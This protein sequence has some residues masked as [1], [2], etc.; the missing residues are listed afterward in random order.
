MGTKKFFEEATEQSLAKVRI[1]SKYFE[2]WANVVGRYEDKVAYID[3]FCG[4]GRYEDGKKSTPLEVLEKAIAD[5]K[6]RDK[7]VS[8]FNDRKQSHVETLESE[9]RALSGVETL[10]YEPKLTC[11]EVDEAVVRVFEEMKLIP[12]LLFVDPWGY[13]GITL[14][15]LKA[16]LKD[17]GCD[18]VLFFNYSRVNRNLGTPL[19]D[20]HMERLFGARR[21]CSLRRKIE[22]EAKV[23]REECIVEEFKSAV[24]ELGGKYVLDFCFKNDQGSRTSHHLMLISKDIKGYDVMKDIMARESSSNTQGV[25]SFE[26]NPTAAMNKQMSLGLDRPID[27]LANELL[28]AFVGKKIK[29]MSVYER[30]SVGKRYIRKNYKDALKKLEKSGKITIDPPSDKR[31]AGTLTDVAW[32][33]FPN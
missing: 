26:F 27:E 16:V 31:R 17:W 32:V 18:C 3:L 10:K 24:R 2:A 20:E 25:P 30:H 8:I 4:P 6:I 28:G 13:K 14:S 11:M 9:I 29:V 19:F 22:F 1:V 5:S 7:L 15:L 23:K 12:T 33:K 21:L